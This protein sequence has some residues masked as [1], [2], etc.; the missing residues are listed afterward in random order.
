MLYDPEDAALRLRRVLQGV[1]ETYYSFD[2]EPF[3][4]ENIGQAVGKLERTDGTTPFIVAYTTQHALG[5]H[6][7][8]VNGGLMESFRIIGTISDTEAAKGDVP[9]LERAIPK[10]QGIECGSI[11]HQLGVLFSK[12]PYS[13]AVRKLLLEIAP[14]CK[15]RLP[16]RAAKPAVATRKKEGDSKVKSAKSTA[17]SAAPKKQSA[18]QTKTPKKPAAKKPTQKVAA[19]KS[20]SKKVARKKKTPKKTT[21]KKK[22]TTQRLSKKKPK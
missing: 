16:K 2:L 4:K 3:V 17:D 20:A 6:A 18:K 9:G 19:S 11:F 22:S 21:K 13:P 12:N 8:P 1:F 10:N 15:D 14:D 5:G 7:I